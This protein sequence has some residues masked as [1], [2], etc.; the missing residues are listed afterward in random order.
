MPFPPPPQTRETIRSWD[1]RAIQDFGMPGIVLMENA[2][3]GA[4]RIIAELAREPEPLPQPFVILCGPGNN[5]GDGFVI[6]RHLYNRELEVHV[7][8]AG[9]AEYAESSDARVNLDI[10]KRM[11]IPLS[12]ALAGPQEPAAALG[13]GTIVDALF[14]TGLSRPLRAPFLDWV[15]AVNRN[16]RP[17]VAVDIPSGLDAN[18]GEIL[19]AAVFADHTITFAASKLG[20]ER[21]EGPKHCGRVHVVDIGMPRQI[22]A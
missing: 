12:L 5:G 10:L 15:E 20:F 21:G 9:S 14:G 13:R 22:W 3:A 18:T 11:A 17:V 4:A 16:G 1:L 8:I 19:G 2:G 7:W 6:A